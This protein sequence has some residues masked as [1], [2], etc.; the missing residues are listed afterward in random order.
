MSD[1]LWPFLGMIVLSIAVIG[2][3]STC[4]MRR[5]P[6]T[7]DEKTWPCERFEDRTIDRVPARCIDFFDKRRPAKATNR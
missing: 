3:V 4:A 6:D 1:P 2:G 5:W 7:F